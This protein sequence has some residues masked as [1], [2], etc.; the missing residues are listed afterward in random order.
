[1]T[2]RKTSLETVLP[3]QVL[4]MDGEQVE[5]M[6]AELVKKTSAPSMEYGKGR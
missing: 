5:Q 4:R 1:M 2:I 6:I 3:D